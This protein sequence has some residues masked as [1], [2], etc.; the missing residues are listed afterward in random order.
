[1]GGSGGAGCS[2]I[3]RLWKLQCPALNKK[4]QE[5][6]GSERSPPE[7][8][9]CSLVTHLPLALWAWILEPGLYCGPYSYQPG[10]QGLVPTTPVPSRQQP[11]REGEVTSLVS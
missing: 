1:M 6:G 10:A 7:A 9:G 4:G 2:E 11:P 8:T 3:M 5:T